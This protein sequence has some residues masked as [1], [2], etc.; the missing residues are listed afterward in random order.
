MAI[1]R[2]ESCGVAAPRSLDGELTCG[3]SADWLR[4]VTDIGSAE[5]G[6]PAGGAELS[7]CSGASELGT[8]CGV[9]GA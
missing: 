4:S 1:G 3:L 2:S 8:G 7:T 6:T 5:L 9:D